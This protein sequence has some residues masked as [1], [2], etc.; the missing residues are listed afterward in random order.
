VPALASTGAFAILMHCAMPR[1]TR[2]LTAAVSTS[3]S[4]KITLGNGNDTVLGGSGDTI[5]AGNGTDTIS[6]GAN[7]HVM[8][9]NN[10][11]TI[12]VGDHSTVTVGNGQDSVTAGAYATIT[13]G[14]GPDIVTAGANANITLGNGSDSVTTGAN[15]SIKLG[16]DTLTTGPN[17]TI[18]VGNGSD[19]IY[20]GANDLINLGKGFDMVAFGESPN[21]L[22]IGNETINGFNPAQD[23]I[24]FNPALLANYAA[25]LVD[26]KQ[27]GANTVIQIDSTESVTLTNVT[28]TSLSANNLH[29]VSS[30]I[31]HTSLA[32][33]TQDGHGSGHECAQTQR[34][35]R[36]EPAG[37]SG[38]RGRE[39]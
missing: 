10:P 33:R 1:A 9:G 28:A 15:S 24:Q 32:G 22:A 14:N 17:S 26:T 2:W 21:L 18:T 25:A 13:G 29:S 8:V 19:T 38:R 4:C 12:T 35:C 3:I 39:F 34:R 20:A 31:V 23:I 11:D 30:D 36:Q 16:S 37:S 6:T 27:V 5:Q 7:S